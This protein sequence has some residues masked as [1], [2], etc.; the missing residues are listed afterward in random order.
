MG[1]EKEHQCNNIMRYGL[2]GLLALFIFSCNNVTKKEYQD[3]QKLWGQLYKDVEQA[4]LFENPKEFWD[5]APLGKPESI[6]KHYDSEKVKEGF[7]LKTFIQEN[8]TVPDYS[9]TYTKS[10]DN[11]ETYVEK[12][13]RSLITRP[14]DDQGSLIPTRMQYV[15]GGGMFKEYNYFTS[16]FAVNA[17]QALGEDSLASSVATNSFQFIQDYGYVPYGN[18]S[19]YLGFSDL[20]VLSL[21]GE[22]V[23]KKQPDLLPW[24][25]NLMA[26]DYQ[27]K[28]GMGETDKVAYAE[29][30]K[31]NKKDFKTVIFVEKERPLNRY[32][33]ESKPNSL[34]SLLKS[35]QWS[36]SSRFNTKNL[37]SIVPVDLNALMFHFETTLSESFKA[38]GRNEYAES[39]K[40][41]AAKRKELLDKYLYNAEKGF[42]YDYDFVNQKQTEAETLA[43]VFPV[44]TGLSDAKQAEA[45]IQKIQQSFLTDNGVLNDLSQETGSAEMNYLTIL[46]LR[47]AG[48]TELADTL[49]N[50]WITL[51]KEYFAKNKHILPVY[52]LK[53][54]ELS[55]KTPARIDGALAVLITLLNE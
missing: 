32:F 38:K 34:I 40:N 25:G 51:N 31:N 16:F 49:K 17:L 46:A 54:P 30:I 41:L 21:T 14:K 37:E 3:P 15:S 39:Y 44:L 53:N 26:R 50:R 22:Q 7:N 52:N 13:F 36:S 43:G 33:S 28:M 5:A 6:L 23:A 48:K 9:V 24:F 45:V 19:Y 55:V 18:R 35:T 12:E 2:I 11:F 1:K 47:R 4:K 10:E 29:A 42:Y 8:F 20:P 27:V